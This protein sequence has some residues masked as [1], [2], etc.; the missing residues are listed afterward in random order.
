MSYNRG[1]YDVYVYDYSAGGDC[2]ASKFEN[3]PIQYGQFLN[4]IPTSRIL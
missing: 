3:D 2:S 1:Y 4:E